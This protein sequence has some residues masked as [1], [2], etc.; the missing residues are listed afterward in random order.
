MSYYKLSVSSPITT[1]R[2][3]VFYSLVTFLMYGTALIYAQ[4]NPVKSVERSFSAKEQV[5]IS[6]RYGPLKIMPASDGKIKV[7]GHLYGEAADAGDLET[8]KRYFE[9][10]I[11]EGS[12]ELDIVTHFKVKNWNTNNG[13]T[14]L[15]FEDGTRINRLKDLKIEATV[16]V[17]ASSKLSVRNKYDEITIMDGTKNDLSVNIYSGRI[18]VGKIGGRLN[19]EAKYS[20]GEVGDFGNAELE[21]YDSDLKFGNGENVK[22]KSKYSDLEMGSYNDMDAN[23]YDDEIEW[24]TIRGQLSIDDKYSEF[25]IGRFNTAKMDIYDSEITSDGGNELLVKSKYTEFNFKEVGQLSFENSYDDKVEIERLGS[26]SANSKYTEYKI[27]KLRNKI[28]LKSYDDDFQVG[29]MLG[30]LEGIEFD[31]K[32]TD[33]T[34]HLP[35]SSEFHLEANM[36]YGKLNYPE[37]RLESQIYKEKNDRLEFRG[38]TKGATDSS[39]KITITSYDGKISID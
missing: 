30:P 15:E 38:S 5:T 39:P 7:T 37:T 33:M 32:Y 31:G 36:T 14:K 18:K 35:P 27:G 6:H 17:P 24:K 34:I 9:F 28:F 8:L 10:D 4:G 23:T 20:K 25:T 3:K 1:Y 21:I 26:F 2:V 22:L 12:D 19:L 11:S 13:V 16:Y 29:E